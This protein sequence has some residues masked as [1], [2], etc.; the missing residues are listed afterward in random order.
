MASVRSITNLQDSYCVLAFCS[1]GRLC[2]ANSINWWGFFLLNDRLFAGRSDERVDFFAFITVFYHLRMA[3][4]FLLRDGSWCQLW[5]IFFKRKL[6]FQMWIH[7][8]TWWDR[9]EKIIS[10][11]FSILVVFNLIYTILI[12]CFFLQETFY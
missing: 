10:L 6:N 9:K 12:R 11:Q 3:Y 4:F 8:S 5:F 2:Q 1:I 7:I